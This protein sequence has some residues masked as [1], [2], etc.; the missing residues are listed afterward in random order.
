LKKAGQLAVT[1][2]ASFGRATKTLHITIKQ[3]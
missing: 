3:P 2:Q 1:I